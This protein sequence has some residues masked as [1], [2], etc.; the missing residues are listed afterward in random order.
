MIYFDN[1][2]T[3]YPK[4]RSVFSS[5]VEALKSF[6][7]NSGRGGYTE[8]IDTAGKIF[9]T[10]EKI[11]DFFTS[12]PENIVFTNN[13]T[14]AL[15]MAIKGL[16]KPN[17]HVLISSLEHNAVARPVH[18]LDSEDKIT[19][20]IVNYSYDSDEFMKEFRSKINQKTCLVVMM[21]ASNVFGVAF[22]IHEVGR[23]CQNEGIPFVLDAAQSA[24]VLPINQK[25]DGISALCAPGHKGLY[26]MMGS[27]F[28]SL[29]DDITLQTIIEGG[30]GS[31]SGTLDQPDIM[32]DRLESG[33][34]NNS[35]IIALG[36]GIDFI[37]S[38]KMDKIYSHEHSLINY[39]YEE[40]KKNERVKLY[41]PLNEIAAPII[42]FNLDDY[43]SEKTAALLADKGIAVRAGLHCAPLAHRFF[44]TYERGT[45]RI[46]PSVFTTHRDC[47]ILLQNLQRV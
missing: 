26:G 16:V 29:L 22:P 6:S 12:S 36:A 21:H 40:M 19:Y 9:E 46:C 30:T 7:F 5:T 43:S 11:A 42:S 23:L 37:N 24:G 1:G 47:E 38:K 10:R 13:C 45:V 14:V 17:G 2:A 31:F 20:D 4:P 28:L 15:N 3:T 35:G 41:V 27:G 33:T 8:S 25:K 34:L 32:P 39:L 44:E 18:K